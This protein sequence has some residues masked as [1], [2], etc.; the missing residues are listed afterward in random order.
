[1][2]NLNMIVWLTQL[3]LGVALPLAGFIYL[4]ILARDYFSLGAWVVIVGAALG[5]IS[6]ISSL[7]SSLKAMERMSKSDHDDAPPPISFNNHD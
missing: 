1:M 4:S 7:R 5:M 3:G 6:A 2:K